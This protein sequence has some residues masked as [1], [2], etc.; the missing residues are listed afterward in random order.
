MKMFGGAGRPFLYARDKATIVRWLRLR[1]SEIRSIPL[2]AGL[3]LAFLYAG[4]LAAQEEDA[5]YLRGSID[6]EAVE[7][8]VHRKPPHA[9]AA[10]STLLPGLHSF[11]IT[12]YTDE[13]FSREGSVSIDF[14]LSDDQIQEP[15]VLYFP[16][17]PLHP[18]FSYGNDHGTGDLVI[19]N[20]E[21]DTSGARVQGRYQGE[22]YYHQ[23]P[24]TQ[25]IS[26]RTAEVEIEFNLISI[27]Q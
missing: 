21:F 3:L 19:E 7:W 12:G 1:R 24:N 26:R 22:L 6:G 23:S 20:V 8:M 18:R 17:N 16:F 25:P 11:R 9:S 5:E 15:K 4:G 14:T 2:L 13:R 10:F 27:R